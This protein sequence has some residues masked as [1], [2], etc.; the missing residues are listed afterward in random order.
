MVFY[1][2][3]GPQQ[4]QYQRLV[5]RFQLVC[6]AQKA[7]HTSARG[8]LVT[9]H[10]WKV[11]AGASSVV[12]REALLRSFVGP[13]Q[14]A[15]NIAVPTMQSSSR[16]I[17][18][19]PDRVLSKDGSVYAEVPYGDLHAVSNMHRFI[20]DGRVPADATVVDTTWKYVNKSGGPDRRFKHNRQLPVAQYS[21]VT[22]SASTGLSTLL[23]FSNAEAAGVL[24]DCLDGMR[25]PPAVTPGLRQ[26]LQLPHRPVSGP[27]PRPMPAPIPHLVGTTSPTFLSSAGA[28]SVTQK[29]GHRRVDAVSPWAPKSLPTGAEFVPLSEDGRL[30]VVGESH[31]QTAL[32]SAVQ[33]RPAG[34]GFDEHLPVTAVLVP[35]PTNPYDPNAVRVD[36][37]SNGSSEIVGYLARAVA[38]AYQPVLLALGANRYGTCAARI[39]GGGEKYY[40]IYLHLAGPEVLLFANQSKCESTGH[41]ESSGV[42]I[43]SPEVQCTVTGEEHHQDHLLPFA[44]C[45]PNEATRVLVTFGY[46]QIVNGKYRGERAIEVRL[47]GER[48]GQ[49]TH[50]MTQRYASYVN[51]VACTGRIPAAEA[52]V[53]SGSRGAQIELRMPS[54][55]P[56]AQSGL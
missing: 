52:V 29:G 13:P 14:M 41:A 15:P 44:P 53:M 51:A 4:V 23:S 33:G 17:Y 5:D 16:S 42:A 9:T 31:Y 28:S 11:N 21:Q 48:V 49:L 27:S 18:L 45:N 19:L 8:D 46:C 6:G 34:E 39:T 2:V 43:L 36:V 7:W 3:D 20:E 25:T 38:A 56:T 50:A 22:L 12:R 37:R 32:W 30:A 47:D 1:E 24:A 55:T 40:G 26:S 35:E 10:Q 54:V